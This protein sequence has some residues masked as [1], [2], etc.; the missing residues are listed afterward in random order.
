MTQNSQEPAP[1]ILARRQ[2]MKLM[3]ELHAKGIKQLP[4]ERQLCKDF[5]VGRVTIRSVLKQLAAECRII[6]APRQGL[7]ISAGSEYQNIGLVF[8]DASTVSFIYSP[9]ILAGIFDA[10]ESSPAFLRNI[11]LREPERLP[12]ILEEYELDGCIWHMPSNAPFA[13]NS[14]AIAQSKIPVMSVLL[15][16]CLPHEEKDLPP[17]RVEPDF[18][19]IGRLRTEFMLKRGHSRIACFANPGTFVHSGFMAAMKDARATHKSWWSIGSDEIS[20]KLPQIL[21]D[22]EAT[23][24]VANGGIAKIEEILNTVEA[25]P[26]GASIELLLD[27]TGPELNE[28]IGN[29]KKANVVAINHYPRKELGGVAA[30]ALLA[31]LNEGKPLAGKKVLSRIELVEKRP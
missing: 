17:I 31:H 15:H 2:L 22:G 5:G 25:H 14:A 3:K 29:F 7:F 30:K 9:A 20:E 8:G 13:R 4:G 11:Q 10:I 26:K 6:V 27:Y 19:G 23:A 1:H 16:A 28:L 24:L 21:N 18:L 12:S